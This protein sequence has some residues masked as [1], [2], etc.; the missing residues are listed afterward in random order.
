MYC[1]D[2]LYEYK[3][4]VIKCEDCGAVLLPGAPPEEEEGDLPEMETAELA[5]VQN[6]V[7]AAALRAMLTDQDIY[8]FMRSNILPHTGLNLSFFNKKSYGTIIVN[9]EDLEKAQEVLV[10]FRRL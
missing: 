6:D 7:E 1:P 5:E 2:C 8:S 3:E 4:G 9:K 10:D